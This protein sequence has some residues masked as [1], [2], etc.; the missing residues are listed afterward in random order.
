MITLRINGGINLPVTCEH[1][2]RE[3]SILFIEIH[4]QVN[5]YINSRIM[6]LT[7]FW[8]TTVENPEPEISSLGRILSPSVLCSSCI[9]IYRVSFYIFIMDKKVLVLCEK[10]LSEFSSY[11]YV[12]RPPESEKTVFTKVCLSVCRSCAA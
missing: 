10:S 8:L 7:L 5:C 9:C 11:L 2:L 12:L 4:C 1:N 3:D 6:S